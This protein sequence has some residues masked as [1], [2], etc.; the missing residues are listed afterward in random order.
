MDLCNKLISSAVFPLL[1]ACQSV[2]TGTCSVFFQTVTNNS[3]YYHFLLNH[4]SGKCFLLS[5]PEVDFLLA[6]KI[7]TQGVGLALFE[8]TSAVGSPCV[9]MKSLKF[10]GLQQ[11]KD[12]AR[13]FAIGKGQI[14]PSWTSSDSCIWF[15]QGMRYHIWSSKAVSYRKSIFMPSFLLYFLFPLLTAGIGTWYQTRICLVQRWCL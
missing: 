9:N 6:K 2:S 10:T 15:Q 7:L 4:L 5:T 13:S 12:R 3:E 11:W 8:S 14:L 1:S